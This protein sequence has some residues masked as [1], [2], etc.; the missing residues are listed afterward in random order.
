MIGAVW[1]AWLGHTPQSNRDHD[2]GALEGEHYTID[3]E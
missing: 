1:G 2:G 3:E